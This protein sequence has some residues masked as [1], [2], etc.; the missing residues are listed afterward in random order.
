MRR[1][2]SVP[3]TAHNILSLSVKNVNV[4]VKNGKPA[5]QIIV[6]YQWNLGIWPISREVSNNST[7]C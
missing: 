2:V 7:S 5:F 4:Q 3:T 1:T 6:K